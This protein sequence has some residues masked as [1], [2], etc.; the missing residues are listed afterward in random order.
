M[1]SAVNNPTQPLIKGY[2]VKQVLGEGGFG[3]VYRAYQ[4]LVKREVAVKVILPQF[5]S[6]PDFIRNFETEAQLIAQLEHIH[7]V[8]LYDYWRDPSGAFL[9]MRLLRGGSLETVLSDGQPQPIELVVR[10]VEQIAS[11]LSVAHQRN[12]IH[13]DIK[14]ANILLDNQQNA[15][16]SDFG[17]AKKLEVGAVDEGGIIG[18]PAYIAPEQITNQE[19]T[20]RTDIYSLG[21][22]VFELLTG[23]KAFAANNSSALIIQHL[24]EEIPDPTTYVPALPRKIYDVL[25]IATAKDASNRYSDVVEFGNQV[26]ETLRGQESST[27]TRGIQT[28]KVEEFI[29]IPP[30][31]APFVLT[32]EVLAL[33]AIEVDLVNPYKG[34]RA[35]QQSDSKDFFGREALTETLIKRMANT[36]GVYRLLV[37]VGPSGSGK[38]SVV[39]AGVIPALR[40][41]AIPGSERYFITEMVPSTDAMRELEAALLSVAVTPPDNMDSIL[42]DSNDGLLRLVNEILPD[43]GSELLLL[44]DQFEE[45]FTLTEDKVRARFLDSLQVAVTAPESR[46]RVIVTLRADFY[47]KPLLY[48]EFGALVRERTE[49]VLPL[50]K[51]ELE[52]AIAGPAEQVGVRIEKQLIA[53][54]IEE[55]YEEPGALPLL[56][57]AL[58][59]TFERRTGFLMTLESYLD[60]GG[61]LGSLA[62]RAEELFVEMDEERQEAIRQLFL[63]LVTLGEGTEDTRRRVLRSEL[64][65]QR[66]EDDPLQAVL[67]TYGKYRLLTFSNDP[68]TR[69]PTIEVAHE[70]L[71]RQWKRLREWLA[72]S[73]EDLRV[74]RRLSSAVLEWRNAERDTSFLA[75]GVRLQQFEVLLES[76]YITLTPEESS[77]VEDSIDKREALRLEE[78]ARLERELKLERRAKK[79]MR[80]LSA[81]LFVA[82]LG[83]LVLMGFAFRQRGIA[84]DERDKAERKA[85]ETLSQSLAQQAEQTARDG[86]TPFL[87]VDLAVEANRI[88]DPPAEVQR[89]LAEVI[90]QP[91]AMRR[92]VGH[93]GEVWAVAVSPDG[94]YIVSGAGT[95]AV[96]A[97]GKADNSL[98]LWDAATGELIRRFEGHTDRVYAVAF[99]PDGQR[100]LSGSQDA[101]LILWDT[102]T[103]EALKHYTGHTGPVWSVYFLPDGERAV[104]GS[105]DKTIILWNIESGEILHRFTGHEGEVSALDLSADGRWI[106]SG[107]FD[108]K[109]VILWDVEAGTL[110]KRMNGHA[111]GIAAIAF[112]PDAKQVLSGG[113]DSYLIL[114]NVETGTE[115]RR[116][117]NVPDITRGMDFAPDGKTALS[118]HLD[119][120]IALWDITTGKLLQQFRGH[121]YWGVSVAYSP[122]GQTGI[123]ASWD[124]SLI[125]WDLFG[126]GAEIQRFEGNTDW[127]LSAALS[128]NEQFALSGSRDGR[129]ILW[130][131]QTGAI[132]HEFTNPSNNSIFSVAL[133]PDGTQALAG[134]SDG[135]LV[136]W[137]VTSGE[138]IRRFEGHQ[139]PVRSVAFS[140]DGMQILSGGG[141]VQVGMNRAVDNRI[142]LWDATTGDMIRQF[143][144]HSAPVRSIAFGP[145]GKT[146]L[147]GSDDTTMILWNISSGSIVWTLKGHTDSVWSVAYSS[148]GKMALSGSR[149]T[150]IILWNLET[151]SE[152]R[153][154]DGHSA[155]VRAVVFGPDDQTALSAS[156][157]M[158]ARGLA[159]DNSLILWDLNTGA[160]IRQFKGHDEAVRS[161]V[162]SAD[163]TQALSAADDN[164]LIWW[165]VDSLDGMLDWVYSR[166][167]VYCLID[168]GFGRNPRC[169]ADLYSSPEAE[170]SVVSVPAVPVQTTAIPSEALCPIESSNPIPAEMVDTVH[171]KTDAPYTIGFSN[172]SASDTL[173]EAWAR[174]EA[175]LHPE[176]ENFIIKNA[177][178]DLSQQI[179]DIQDLVAQDIDLLIVNPN[180][181]GDQSLLAAELQKAME[182]G[183]PVLLV[184][185]RINT[186]QYVTF[187]GPDDFKVGCV[188]AQELVA[189]LDGEG[190]PVQFNGID[191]SLSDKLRKAG[192][193]AVVSLYP[194]ISIQGETPTELDPTKPATI[195]KEAMSG[196]RVDGILAYNGLLALRGEE[197]INEMVQSYVPAVADHY[198]G[199]ARLVYE[200]HL[201]A[202]LIRI[203]STMGADAVRVA[204]DILSGNEVSQFVE[205]EIEVIPSNEITAEDLDQPDEGL[206]RDDEGLP[207]EFYP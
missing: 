127:V 34:L 10:W 118:A 108:D 137:D 18:T 16:L 63:R 1:T 200:N 12:V 88:S 26:K 166:Y 167:D 85:D 134:M 41:G 83:A 116:F 35:F 158:A 40:H 110:V 81:V 142:I 131:V 140:A 126:R 90:W 68:Q 151:G 105:S 196:T 168:G 80:A 124:K 53:R 76:Q 163:G 156:G 24:T 144:G 154:L 29:I 148:D 96:G 129:L 138:E 14:P 207:P 203:P 64:P 98:I 60:S 180:E 82:A 177:G 195:I 7:I 100:I 204:L 112:S 147:S 36:E 141:N 115:I 199:F 171:F 99:S 150:H 201:R 77:Y 59:E 130:D 123:S 106:V 149:D 139:A 187:V 66:D 172:A 181:A 30:D 205:I 170:T 45:A 61:V 125:Q 111:S 114:W 101:S 11:A 43:D 135:S 145:D 143:E 178:G 155:A 78:E 120:S 153:R 107:S 79:V 73:R 37:V 17:I 44:I 186:D 132:I 62:R 165:R 50:S 188:M 8:P 70:A 3:A 157:N 67:D 121:D 174:Y 136:L 28:D 102:N 94:K 31:I 179:A 176:I 48:P 42:R 57:Y 159:V 191:T 27:P 65:F 175:S 49:V 109:Q 71:I 122:D 161:L 113:L 91:G 164:L 72:N 184:G 25:R 169:K 22:L 84:E 89:T 160:E 193:A 46:L 92:L 185:H 87:A 194:G 69:E 56:Q 39:K 86:E 192:S 198:V 9:V 162:L 19:I 182:A 13:R 58:T 119:S 54:M 103:G 173:L 74:H 15:Y 95:V 2:E 146:I 6:Q 55:V 128:A 190:G 21:L 197:A 23:Q 202:S 75:S 104:S 206:L 97:D 20:P 33:E 183:I 32:S 5:A 117:E 52:R 133:S 47:H 93:T 152:I 4:P 38:S 51:S 189:L